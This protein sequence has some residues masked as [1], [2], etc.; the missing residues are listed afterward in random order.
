MLPSHWPR[1]LVIPIALLLIAATI[2]VGL[3]L[4]NVTQAI[5]PKVEPTPTLVTLPYAAPLSGGCV[6]CHTNEERLLEELLD[7]SELEKVYIEP[8]DVMSLHGRLGCVT[9]H[10]GDGEAEDLKASHVDMIS[11]P[12]TVEE[13][14]TRCLTCHHR[15][16]TDVPEHF[17]QTPHRQ[18]VMAAHEDP[19]IWSCS[20]CHLAVAHGPTPPDSHERQRQFCIECH[21]E[22]NLPPERLTCHGCHVGPHDVSDALDCEICHISTEHWSQVE[23]AIHP[24]PLTG[25]HGEIHC[26]DCHTKP[27]FRRV[28]NYSCADCHTK[29]HAYGGDNCS[30]CHFDDRPWNQPKE[31]RNIED[32]QHPEPWQRYMG[33]HGDV[34]CQGCH[35]QGYESLSTDCKSCHV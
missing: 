31:L 7:A 1:W 34:S 4:E 3:I 23:L 20:N 28:V 21:E 26:F 33:V 11:N 10:R 32:F 30:Q 17:M 8:D 19:A 24:M 6:D 12:T 13:A 35:F 5:A 18:V 22:L 16:P 27:N 14:E 2:G 29:P 25:T 15:L 9:C